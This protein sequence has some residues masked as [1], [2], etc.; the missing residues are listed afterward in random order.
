MKLGEF[1]SQHA[2]FT[3]EDIDVFMSKRG[4]SNSNTRKSLLTYYRNQG[5]IIPVRRGLYATVPLGISPEQVVVDPYLIAAKA[6]SDSVLAY[7]TALE[8]HGRAYSVYTRHH[9][10]SSINSLPFTFQSIEY[11]GTPIPRALR[12][13]KQ[14]MFGV[15]RFNRL[16]VEV[17]VTT[18]ERALVDVLDRPDLTGSWEEIWRSLESIEY[19]DLDQVM[20]YLL[21][22]GNATTIA[23]AGYFL[24][25]HKKSLMVDD[26]YLNRLR[27][28][29][30][31]QPHYIT[32]QRKECQWIKEWNLIIPL[33]IINQSWGDVI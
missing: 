10:L 7:H 31:L 26:S 22:L 27:S 28:L 6:T 14:V 17:R 4:Q 5:R 16:G 2:V 25:Q 29:R 30:P 21:L 32:R 23:K 15:T 1:F 3:I 20:E 8:F 19:F 24:E 12:E 11:K 9:Y 33:E 18:L 13:K